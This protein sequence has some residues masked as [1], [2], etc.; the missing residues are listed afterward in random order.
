[1]ARP[2]RMFFKKVVRVVFTMIKPCGGENISEWY[3]QHG[4]VGRQH[5]FILDSSKGTYFGADGGLYGRIILQLALVAFLFS[6][7]L[8]SSADGSL[9]PGYQYRCGG[10]ASACYASTMPWKDTVEEA[11]KQGCEVY[12][13]IGVHDPWYAVV[14]CI[15]LNSSLDTPGAEGLPYV[16]LKYTYNL[17]GWARGA[18]DPNVL[19]DGYPGFIA[20]TLYDPILYFVSIDS[21]SNTE[22]GACCQNAVGHPINP[23]NGATFDTL[24]DI[25]DGIIPLEFKRFYSSDDPSSQYINKGWA[26]EFSRKISIRNSALLVQPYVASNV[27]SSTYSDPSTACTNGFYEIKSKV[28]NWISATA[29]YTDGHCQLVHDG[30]LIGTLR[31]YSTRQSSSLAS[32]P[33]E[34]EVVRDDGQVILFSLVNGVISA[35]PG[36]GV[37]LLQTS[38]GYTLTDGNDNVESYD[39]NGKLLSIASRAGVVQTMSYDAAGHLSGVTDSFGHQLSF[40]YDPQ[41]RLSA[42]TRQ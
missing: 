4:R 25:K 5:A 34:F 27:N 30:S 1:M 15:Y 21:P 14:D 16:Y 36:T 42:V 37:K 19:Y 28:Q 38:S 35:P 20:Q 29:L 41:G 7:P 3:G 6:V 17:C 39:A 11:G 32:T 22:P 33:V 10:T 9:G 18:C 26:Y 13:P 12:Y 24:V 8:M 23:V 40:S 2:I 31:V